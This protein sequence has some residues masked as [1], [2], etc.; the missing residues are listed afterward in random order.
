MSGSFFGT[1]TEQE[2]GKRDYKAFES[3]RTDIRLM[4]QIKHGDIGTSID[5]KYLRSLIYDF[6]D[7]TAQRLELYMSMVKFTIIGRNLD[8]MLDKFQTHSVHWIEEFDPERHLEPAPDE[9]FIQ[10]ISHIE[11]E[12][13]DE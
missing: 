9:A 6:R 4:L 1:A 7:P 2:D 12:A 11:L 8:E 3:S 13:G 10:E 5:Y